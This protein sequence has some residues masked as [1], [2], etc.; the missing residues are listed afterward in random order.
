[1]ASKIFISYRRHDAKYQARMIYEAFRAVLPRDNVFM[2]VDSIPLGADFVEI[3]EGW[4]GKCEVLVALI[5]PGW[6]DANDPKSARRRIEYEN[7]FVRIEIRE[8]LKRGIPV[9][10]VLL[11]GTLM[12]EAD[13]LP[14]DLKRLVRR[15]AEF[16][17]FR[18]F[19]SDVDRLIKKLGLGSEKAE[20][21]NREVETLRTVKEHQQRDSEAKRLVEEEKRRRKGEAE[22][23]RIAEQRRRKEAETEQR[24]ADNGDREKREAAVNQRAEAAAGAPKTGA[25][26]RAEEERAF[27]AAKADNTIRMFDAFLEIYPGSY[28]FNEAKTLRASLVERDEAYKRAMNSIDEAVLKAFLDQY[29]ADKLTSHVRNRLDSEVAAQRVASE[30]ASLQQSQ[31]RGAVPNAIRW[32]GGGLIG[33]LLVSVIV[34]VLF[35]SI[36]VENVPI[37]IQKSMPKFI[38]DNFLA[39]IWK[40]DQHRRLAESVPTLRGYFTRIEHASGT[41]ANFSGVYFFGSDCTDNVVY[42][43]AILQ[44]FLL[45]S[46]GNIAYRVG[47]AAPNALLSYDISPDKPISFD[48][49]KGV[50]WGDGASMS[51]FKLT[52]TE[53]IKLPTDEIAFFK[54]KAYYKVDTNN[55][56][57]L[58]RCG[59]LQDAEHKIIDVLIPAILNQ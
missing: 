44:R 18:S 35:P 41:L 48:K 14:D 8:A 47:L 11:D 13:Q 45:W 23:E 19:D 22:A 38:Q 20:P 26:Q 55:F 27:A 2:D 58:T 59:P 7:D 29:P 37:S 16:I 56:K 31:K 21:Q 36:I 32:L 42:Q 3:L 51:L 33:L 57:M 40:A 46:E 28:R 1:M 52:P 12:P 15:Q 25:M 17:E 53:G 34:L 4:V 24:A 10:P 43:L 50:A 39:K 30:I 6:V 54:D 5:G 9:V 49:A